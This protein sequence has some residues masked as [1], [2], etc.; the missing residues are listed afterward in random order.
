MW[1]YF[2]ASG[3][4]SSIIIMLRK[5]SFIAPDSPIRRNSRLSC[6]KST[7]MNSLSYMDASQLFPSL[8]TCGWRSVIRI[9]VS[10]KFCVKNFFCNCNIFIFLKFNE[11]VI[12][13]MCQ[14]YQIRR[15]CTSTGAVVQGCRQSEDSL[16]LEFNRFWKMVT[17]NRTHI[18]LN[19]DWNS[20]ERVGIGRKNLSFFSSVYTQ[21][22]VSCF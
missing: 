21:E 18:C 19:L 20:L 2:F 11:F 22:R 6:S 10:A 12:A 5:A 16:S 9:L 4:P 1:T 13:L 14:R 8:W 3:R 17:Y 7:Q 15:K